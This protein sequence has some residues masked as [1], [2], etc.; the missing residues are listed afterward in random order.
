VGWLVYWRLRALWL[1]SN[2]AEPF[3]SAFLDW[4]RQA[5]AEVGVTWPK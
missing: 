2:P 5:E 4:K 1:A 3:G